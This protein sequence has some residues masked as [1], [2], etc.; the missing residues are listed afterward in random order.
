MKKILYIHGFSSSGTSKT[1]KSLRKLLEDADITAPDL[2]PSPFETLNLLDG[3][4]KELRPDVIIGTSI[5]GMFAQLLRGYKKVLINPA[6]HVS[7]FLR[8]EIGIH[9]YLNPRINGEKEFEVTS[10][11]IMDYSLIEKTQFDSI[12]EVDRNYTYA[13]FGEKDEVVNCRE[14]YCKYYKYYKMFPGEH[15]MTYRDIKD[16]LAPYIKEILY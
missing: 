1:T 7:E 4:C 11:L 12:S 5:G 16:Y 13:L 6:F 3:I 9:P 14:R 2:P 10:S 15:R 8:T